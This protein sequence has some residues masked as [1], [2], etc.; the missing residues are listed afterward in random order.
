M[1]REHY[2]EYAYWFLGCKGLEFIGYRTNTIQQI[3]LNYMR[4]KIVLC[5]SVDLDLS[6]KYHIISFETRVSHDGRLIREKGKEFGV[7]I[8]GI[9]F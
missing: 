2:G 3:L 6:Y 5:L 9:G 1:F 8:K 7:R 4:N